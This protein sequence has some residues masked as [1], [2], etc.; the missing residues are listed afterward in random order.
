MFPSLEIPEEAVPT[1]PTMSNDISVDTVYVVDG[2]TFKDK[3]EAVRYQQRR[4]RETAETLVKQLPQ[5]HDNKTIYYEIWE[6]V[7]GKK[8]AQNVIL[9]LKKPM[10]VL[11]KQLSIMQTNVGSTKSLS[12]KMLTALLTLIVNLFIV[13]NKGKPYEI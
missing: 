3:T 10:N 8:T 6:Q 9:M 5:S 13:T 1:T 12:L 2:V 4:Q 11:V 7:D